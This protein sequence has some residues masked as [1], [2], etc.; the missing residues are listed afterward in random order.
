[1]LILLVEVSRDLFP[2]INKSVFQVPLHV[3]RKE[4]TFWLGPKLWL[5]G[6]V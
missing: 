1:M 5:M 4:L 3:K 2:E 6:T